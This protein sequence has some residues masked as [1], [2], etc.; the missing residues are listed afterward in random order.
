MEISEVSSPPVH[1]RHLVL[2]LQE[3]KEEVKKYASV[4]TSNPSNGSESSTVDIEELV[5]TMCSDEGKFAN[6]CVLLHGSLKV[7]GMVAICQVGN[8]DWYGMLYSWADSKKKSNLMLSTFMCGSD[9][10]PWLG[11]LKSLGFPTLSIP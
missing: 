1:S 7:E 10:I 2:P 8:P 3:S 9:A 5:N 4:M 6:F 11:N